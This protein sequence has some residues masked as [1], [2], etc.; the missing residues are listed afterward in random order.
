MKQKLDYGLAFLRQIPV[1]H[2]RPP[3]IAIFP[4]GRTSVPPDL[5][6]TA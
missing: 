2:R 4:L 6:D 3:M 5:N 1:T